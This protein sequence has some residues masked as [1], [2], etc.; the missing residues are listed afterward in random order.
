MKIVVGGQVWF[1]KDAGLLELVEKLR[2][3]LTIERKKVGDFG[4]DDDGPEMVRLYSET[5]EL[6][7][8]PRSYFFSNVVAQHDYEWRLSLGRPINVTNTLRHEGA[9]AEQ[10]EAID[11]FMATFSTARK[12]LEAVHDGLATPDGVRWVRDAGAILQAKTAWG[13]TAWALGLAARLGVTTLIVVHK[14]FLMRQWVSR[15]RKFLPDAKVGIIQENRCEFE[16]RDFV[17]AMVHSLALDDLNGS[18]YPQGMYDYFGCVIN[19]EVHRISASSWSEVPKRFSALFRIGISATPRRKDG[20]EAVFRHHIGD[21]RFVAVTPAIPAT[22]AV[23]RFNAQF[24][25]K[26]SSGELKSSIV[27]SILAK[28]MTRNRFIARSIIDALRHSSKRKVLV[29][30]HRLEQLDELERL[31]SGHRDAPADLTI[32]HYTGAWY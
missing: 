25:E 28:D 30:S 23:R 7:G 17:V 19:D 1:R 32:G 10:G 3:D 16:G 22:V 2:A 9:Y 12:R 13:K 11:R 29:L 5:D 14:E 20:T 6:F 21:V 8:I 31:I 18:R 4:D 15:I 27:L 24:S 26:V